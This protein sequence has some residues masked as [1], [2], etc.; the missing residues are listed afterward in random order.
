L[1][2]VSNASRTSGFSIGGMIVQ[3]IALQAPDLLRR[4]ILVGTGLRPRPQHALGLDVAAAIVLDF[5]V[6]ANLAFGGQAIV[7]LGPEERSR[8]N[9]LFMASFF[10]GGAVSAPLSGWCYSH[11]GW[12]G[13][14]IPGTALP[15][16]ASLHFTTE[17]LGRSR[18]ALTSGRTR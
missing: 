14:F 7:A 1:N 15:I 18:R 12:I 8:L 11:H 2:K 9:G 6:A 16:L 10:A 5:A 13:A 17:Q 3:E 4:L